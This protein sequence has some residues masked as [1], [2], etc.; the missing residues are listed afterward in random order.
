ML[1][2]NLF[3]PNLTQNHDFYVKQKLCFRDYKLKK[4]IDIPTQTSKIVV[5][6]IFITKQILKNWKKNEAKTCKFRG[7]LSYLALK[8]T[9]ISEQFTNLVSCVMMWKLEGVPQ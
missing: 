8:M 4:I 9:K 7:S 1:Y 6:C 3:W 5:Y 2:C